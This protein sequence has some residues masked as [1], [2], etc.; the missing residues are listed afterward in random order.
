MKLTKIDKERGIGKVAIISNRGK[1]QHLEY[2]LESL[3]D[4]YPCCQR[5]DYKMSESRKK[6]YLVPV[7]ARKNGKRYFADVE[8]SRVDSDSGVVYLPKW[9]NKEVKQENKKLF[10]FAKNYGIITPDQE[11]TLEQVK[12]SITRILD[13][14]DM[15]YSFEYNRLREHYTV[16]AE[17]GELVGEAK[18]A[19]DQFILADREDKASFVLEA[20]KSTNIDDLYER[21][22]EVYVMLQV[23]RKVVE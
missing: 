7:D 13:I 4:W 21:F 3:F 9:C 8:K 23:M 11:Y 22:G 16:L 10:E 15:L 18:K 2:P 17:N 12:D 5:Y 20:C 1:L 19:Y 6:L 14:L